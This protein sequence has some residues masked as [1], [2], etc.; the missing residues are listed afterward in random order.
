MTDRTLS[1]L[2]NAAGEAE[3]RATAARLSSLPYAPPPP[4]TTVRAVRLR[5]VAEATL[6]KR[7]DDPLISATALLLAGKAADAASVLDRA[8]SRGDA[9][10]WSDLAAARHAAALQ[11]RD[12]RLLADALAAADSALA[13]DPE[14]EEGWFNRA[15][16]LDA[17]G[18]RSAAAESLRRYVSID[19]SS[20][21]ASE[22]RR[23]LRHAERQSNEEQWLAVESS[24]RLAA[25]RRDVAT[26]ARIARQFPQHVRTSGEG[27]Y[28][29]AWANAKGDDAERHLRLLETAGAG[30]KLANGNAFLADAAALIRQTADTRPLAAACRIYTD[31]RAAWRAR[32]NARAFEGFTTATRLST[33]IASPMELVASYYRAGAAFALHDAA[34]ATAILDEL[35]PRVPE[36]YPAL[37]AQILWQR[38]LHVGHG[39]SLYE[40]LSFCRRA[41]AGFDRLGE[42]GFAVRMRTNEISILTFL[43]RQREAWDSRISLFRDA[44]DF[45]LRSIL[46]EALYS[47]AMDEIDAGR[48]A[49]AR[50]LFALQLAAPA[51]SPRQHF[52]AQLGRAVAEAKLHGRPLDVRDAELAAGRLHDLA[53]RDEARDQIRA[54]LGRSLRD[55]EPARAVRLLS[56]VVEYR[57]SSGRTADLPFVYADRA[58]AHQSAGHFADAEQDLQTAAAMIEARGARI[59]NDPWRDVFFGTTRDVYEQ[60]VEL[61][62]ARGDRRRAVEI[63]D[64][65]RARVLVDSPASTAS[66]QQ[67]LPDDVTVLHITTLSDRTLVAA[68]DRRRLVTALVPAGRAKVVQ[69]TERLTHAVERGDTPAA[70][71]AGSALD[72][73]LLRSVGITSHPGRLLIVVPDESTAAIPFA[74]LTRPTGRF[75]IEETAIAFAPNAGVLRRDIEPRS[76]RSAGVVSDPAADRMVFPGLQR[77]PAAASDARDLRG[78][79]D[80]VHACS[81]TAAT[82]ECMLRSL[83]GDDLVHVAAHAF[84]NDRDASLSVIALALAATDRGVL[85]LNEIASL[86]LK[87]APFVV[88]AGCRTSATGGGKGSIRSLSLAFLAAGSSMVLGTLSNVDDEATSALTTRFYGALSQGLPPAEALRAVQLHMI[89]NGEGLSAWSPFQLTVS[90]LTT[91]FRTM[92]C[93][94][95][96]KKNVGSSSLSDDVVFQRADDTHR[97]GLGF[98]GT[99]ETS[100]RDRRREKSSARNSL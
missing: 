33:R 42:R 64:R 8:S 95:E 96:E 94:Q 35:E 62:L 53:L 1:R 81:G 26:V 87:N 46:E 54:L 28:L 49:S 57:S 29:A 43:G 89:R 56:H 88:L 22:A 38:M 73:L 10:V 36:R 98:C 66:I 67:R 21:W 76:I 15:I 50:S 61:A 13:I 55:R 60:W 100:T 37:R 24:F 99:E 44:E 72:A 23:R 41:M 77:L 14:S 90:G 45:G 86:D 9:R 78:I 19:A 79:F 71:S 91:P 4:D 59:S 3:F 12:V 2:R 93:T 68:L 69:L 97:T 58:S 83:A 70:R 63:A 27:A 74:A 6:A 16:V 82:R 25:E 20:E 52:D 11:S 48:W 75:L 40:S 84:S 31:A 65:G 5:A 30:L 80:R 7:H 32:D 39:G 92:T 51:T 18:L 85:S 17:L 34:A 47:A